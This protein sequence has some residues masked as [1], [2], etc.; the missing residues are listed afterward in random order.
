MTWALWD[1]SR[2]FACALQRRHSEPHGSCARLPDAREPCLSLQA[3]ADF[4]RARYCSGRTDKTARVAGNDRSP[5]RAS[6]SGRAL[7]CRRRDGRVMVGCVACQSERPQLRSSFAHGVLVCQ[8]FGH[9]LLALTQ[10]LFLFLQGGCATFRGLGRVGAQRR[11]SILS[12][13]MQGDH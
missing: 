2:D 4:E 9:R 13:S 8:V 1:I 11:N 3:W 5:G 10:P 7:L 6:Y 12:R